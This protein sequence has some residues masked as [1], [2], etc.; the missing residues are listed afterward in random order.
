MCGMFPQGGKADQSRVRD[1][2]DR[3]WRIELEFVRVPGS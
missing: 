2:N 1:V 3:V